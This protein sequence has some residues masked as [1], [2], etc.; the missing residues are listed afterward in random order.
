MKPFK[1]T[2]TIDITVLAMSKREAIDI[3]E[4]RL[5]DPRFEVLHVERV[6]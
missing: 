3:V 6:D 1:Y 4:K 5:N 2:V